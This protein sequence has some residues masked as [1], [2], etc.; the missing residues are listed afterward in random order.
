MTSK[1]QPPPEPPTADLLAAL[2][3]AVNEA[4]ADRRLS[5]V[6]AAAAHALEKM[7][8]PLR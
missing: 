6:A 3:R 1:P 7:G 2:E 4:K 8:E 5:A